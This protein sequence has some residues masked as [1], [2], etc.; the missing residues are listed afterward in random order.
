[1]AGSPARE[2]SW[3]AKRYYPAPESKEEAAQWV[4]WNEA[5]YAEHGCGLW[6]V[7]THDGEF[8]GD[9]GLIWQEVNGRSE[10]EVGYHMR[11]DVQGRG[12]GTEAASACR[13]FARDVLHVPQL[14]VIIHPGNVSSRRVAER[15]ACIGSRTTTAALS[16][17]ASYSPSSSGSDRRSETQSQ[18]YS[19]APFPDHDGSPVRV[20]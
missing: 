1:M 10:L 15:S 19:V 6:V 20:P 4:A 12:Y 18:A 9:C 2:S 13:D 11:A 8:L 3:S 16:P 7:E 17:S 5:N 14:V